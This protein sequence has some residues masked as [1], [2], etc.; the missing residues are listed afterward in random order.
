MFLYLCPARTQVSGVTM[1]GVSLGE[2][3]SF[4]FTNLEE[5]YLDKAKLAWP[6][7]SIC[8]PI[9]ITWRCIALVGI[10][11]LC[12]ILLLIYILLLLMLSSYW[13]TVSISISLL[14]TLYG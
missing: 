1:D 2:Y 7:A 3:L 12:S 5:E 14:S 6:I 8:F 13:A 10:R 11:A 9:T 4:S